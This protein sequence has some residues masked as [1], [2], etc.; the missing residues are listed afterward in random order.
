MNSQTVKQ[1]SQICFVAGAASVA[2]SAATYLIGQRR[3]Q[4]STRNTGVFMGLWAPTFFALAE[5]L[6]RVSIE[7]HRY[8]G[9]SIDHPI[10]ERARE[11]VRR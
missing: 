1:L 9:V 3:D 5:I 11:L 2:L 4:D 8:M 6:D 7:D 10:S